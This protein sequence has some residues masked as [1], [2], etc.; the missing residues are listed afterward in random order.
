MTCSSP[1]FAVDTTLLTD[2]DTEDGAPE[3]L[4]RSSADQ[5]ARKNP[6]CVRRPEEVKLAT[7]GCE[8]TISPFR[9]PALQSVP[10]E[11]SEDEWTVMD[12]S[13]EETVAEEDSGE[14]SA[15]Q[16]AIWDRRMPLV[17]YQNK[18]N[19]ELREYFAT[20]KGH[21]PAEDT[22]VARLGV[23]LAPLSCIGG[24]K[25]LVLDLDGTLICSARRAK[26]RGDTKKQIARVL[27]KRGKGEK[28]TLVEFMVRPFAVQMLRVLHV[29]YEIVVSGCDVTSADRSSAPAGADMPTP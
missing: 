20:L 18:I 5:Q 28:A 3:T 25:T 27:V 17:P 13:R 19:D 1:T 23:R 7:E 2:D 10:S 8:S 14:E 16:Q 21:R 22:S 9:Q 6:F 26:G 15:R 29:F 11:E 12:A 24:K 4:P